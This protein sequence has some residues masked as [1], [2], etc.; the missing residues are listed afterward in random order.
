MLDLIAIVVVLMA[1]FSLVVWM[2]QAQQAYLKLHA[3]RTGARQPLVQ[4]DELLRRYALRP[5]RWFIEAPALI[6][7]AMRATSKIQTDP[8]LEM[9]RLQYIYRR[10]M[11]LVLGIISFAFLM[12]FLSTP[13]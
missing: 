7:D 3:T 13:R 5:W 11:M 4:G 1:W 2:G 10:R 6:R 12:W 9:V 8:D